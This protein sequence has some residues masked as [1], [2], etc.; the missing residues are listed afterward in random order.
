MTFWERSLKGA[1]QVPLLLFILALG[2]AGGIAIALSLKWLELSD[3][4]A[5]FVGGVVGATLGS[6]FA[7]FASSALAAARDR[8]AQRQYAEMLYVEFLR[9]HVPWFELGEAVRLRDMNEAA[10]WMRQWPIMLAFQEMQVA[11]DDF[12]VHFPL[13]PEIGPHVIVELRRAVTRCREVGQMFF[14][15]VVSSG[16]VNPENMMDTMARNFDA[17]HEP[18]AAALRQ[19]EKIA[20]D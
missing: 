16:P 15:L 10:Q 20:R 12:M 9:M 14:G 6:A 5:N 8:K 19:L 2:G 3:N 11:A 17:W 1:Y 13:R 4:M 7:V 18:V